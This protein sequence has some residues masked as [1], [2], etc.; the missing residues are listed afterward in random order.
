[1][2]KTKIVATIGPAT[3]SFE[4]LQAIINE[5]VDVVRLNFSHGAHEDHASV[6][7]H[8]RKINDA[9]I[10]KVA[11]LA[12]LQGPKLRIGEVE[13]NGVELKDGEKIIIST[14]SVVGTSERVSTNYQM[15]AQDVEPGEEVRLDD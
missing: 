7:E 5:G 2:K 13:N 3:S 10:N 14:N 9:S 4:M 1:M 8:V 12:D 6:I 15:F 11:I